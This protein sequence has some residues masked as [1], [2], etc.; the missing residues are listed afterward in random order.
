MLET[1]ENED[2]DNSDGEQGQLS[3]QFSCSTTIKPFCSRLSLSKGN[4]SQY[5]TMEL[6]YRRHLLRSLPDYLVIDCSMFSYID[7]DGVKMIRRLIKDFQFLNVKV[8]LGGCP[9]HVGQL[10]EQSDLSRN[11]RLGQIIYISVLDAIEHARQE[12]QDQ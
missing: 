5:S 2:E 7:I 11:D 6:Q 1:I 12:Q 4:L 9:S 3:K 10:L 8:F